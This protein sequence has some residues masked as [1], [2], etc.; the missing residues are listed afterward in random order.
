MVEDFISVGRLTT[1]RT[2]FA[3]EQMQ[4]VPEVAASPLLVDSI[5]AVLQRA[6]AVRAVNTQWHLQLG[7]PTRRG[8]AFEYDVQIDHTLG[9]VDGQCL[10][11]IGGLASDS[12]VAQLAGGFRARRMP[13]G[14]TGITQLPFEDELE[15]VETFLACTTGDGEDVAAV[16][17]LGLTP[18]IERLVE[19]V[20]K[21]K[22]ELANHPREGGLSFDQ[23][24]A[25]REALHIELCFLV[26]D[27]VSAFKRQP[28]VLA[29]AL[30]PLRDQLARMAALR[31]GRRKVVVDVEPGTGA[32]VM[33]PAEA[34][35]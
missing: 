8:Q 10:S 29:Q 11:L 23:V 25:T 14:L 7:R 22:A 13:R 9:G 35:G 19:L 20:P 1:G 2:I 4:Q 21:F 12:P 26:A 18:Y 6:R 15:E 31:A 16:Q 33:A 28:A 24:R 30:R 3:L 32:E 27:V 34:E 5:G 17:K